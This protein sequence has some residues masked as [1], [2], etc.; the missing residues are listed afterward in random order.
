MASKTVKIGIL[1]ICPVCEGEFKVR[2]GKLVHHGFTRP[3]DGMIHGDCFA[4]GY[5]PYERSVKGCQDY[6]VVVV[7]QRKGVEDYLARLRAGKV[8]YFSEIQRF[9]YAHEIVEYVAGVTEPYRFQRLI[10]EKIRDCEYRI[11]Q[12]TSEVARMDRLIA[13]WSLKDLREVTEE[14]ASA[15]VKAERDARAAERATKK[16]EKDAKRAALEA[17]RAARAA[18]REAA[19]KVLVNALTALDSTETPYSQAERSK[20]AL[21]VWNTFFSKKTEREL[22]DLLEFKY[23]F[24]NRGLDDLLV[25]LGL[26]RHESGGWV[27]YLYW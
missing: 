9:G 10:E 5:E 26:A 24:R 12:L 15:Q 4:V 18:K 21:E 13:G 14:M 16:A 2:D 11:R 3:G 22:G 19:F 6:K 27:N 1:G 17:K 7:D 23:A 20:A 8:T 25:R